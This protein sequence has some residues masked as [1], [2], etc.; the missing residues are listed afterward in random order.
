M[1]ETR[2]ARGTPDP[3][4]LRGSS[5]SCGEVKRA[6][7][8]TFPG[9]LNSLTNKFIVTNG[10]NPRNSRDHRNYRTRPL[11][12]DAIGNGAQS[13]C[14]RVLVPVSAAFQRDFAAEHPIDEHEVSDRQRH[15]D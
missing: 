3:E 10:S 14:R 5:L 13:I 7:S 1:A 6:G 2:L 12:R 4:E 8:Y 11:R 9:E 15:T